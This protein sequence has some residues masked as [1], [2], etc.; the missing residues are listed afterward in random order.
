MGDLDAGL[1]TL[2]TFGVLGLFGIVAFFSL[3]RHMRGITAPHEAELGAAAAAKRQGGSD[4]A[5]DAPAAG[6]A[7]AEGSPATPPGR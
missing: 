6:P 3:R 4:Q 2:L 7:A 5:G 1:L